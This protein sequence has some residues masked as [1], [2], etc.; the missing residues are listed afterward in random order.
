MNATDLK[1][2]EVS[3]DGHIDVEWCRGVYESETVSLIEFGLNTRCTLVSSGTDGKQPVV[4]IADQDEVADVT[5]PHFAGY[6]IWS[7]EIAKDVL[8]VT[9]LRKP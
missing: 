9:F 2:F 7:A 4:T 1:I 3:E 8:R 6:D 5:F